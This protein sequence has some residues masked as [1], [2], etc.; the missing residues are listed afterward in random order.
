MLEISTSGLMSGDGKRS[1]VLQSIATA[2]VLDFTHENGPGLHAL[3]HPCRLRYFVHQVLIH[4]SP[5]AEVLREVGAFA[6]ITS[7]LR[8]GD[9]SDT[10]STI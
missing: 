9:S 4:Q 6:A 1:G 2:P 7:R 5:T 3:L 10:C 8:S